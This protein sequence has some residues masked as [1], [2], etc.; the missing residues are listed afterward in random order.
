MIALAGESR[1]S[2]ALRA[3][4]GYL[5]LPISSLDPTRNHAFEATAIEY[6]VTPVAVTATTVSISARHSARRQLVSNAPP[7]T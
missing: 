2:S 4:L 6:G 7:S 3:V 5:R 1:S